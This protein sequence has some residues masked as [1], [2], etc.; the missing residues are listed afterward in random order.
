MTSAAETDASPSSIQFPGS[1]QYNSTPAIENADELGEVPANELIKVAGTREQCQ[2]AIEVLS[3]ALSTP[4]SRSGT[5]TGRGNGNLPTRTVGV[6]AKYFHSLIDGQIQRQLRQTGIQVELPAAPAKPE[7]KR[8]E[9]AS[10]QAGAESARIDIDAD[11]DSAEEI[12]YSFEVYDKYEGL[13]EEGDSI[14]DFVIRGKEEVLQ[15]GE[16][17]KLLPN[18]PFCDAQYTIDSHSEGS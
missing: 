13:G 9:T 12:N 14:L 11:E 16:E 8:P 17:S 3:Q 1:R 7:F 15:K 6:P 2:R 4:P 18:A 10:K 5:P